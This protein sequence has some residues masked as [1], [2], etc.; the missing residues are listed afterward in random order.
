M[1]W[2]LLIS[3]TWAITGYSSQEECQ[4]AAKHIK[5]GY[6]TMC[7]PKSSTGQVIGGHS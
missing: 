5:V 6:S 7:I 1:S 3:F 4:A 2:V